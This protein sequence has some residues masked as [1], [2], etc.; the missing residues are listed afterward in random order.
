MLGKL[1]LFAIDN[2]DQQARLQT[3]ADSTALA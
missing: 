3:V 2:Q 1:K